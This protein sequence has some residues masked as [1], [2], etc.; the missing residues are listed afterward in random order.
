L[1]FVKIYLQPIYLHGSSC[2]GALLL[3]FI[4][5]IRVLGTR[6]LFCRLHICTI[7]KKSCLNKTIT[8]LVEWA[9]GRESLGN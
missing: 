3:F 1:P 6:E 2:W 5:F 4:F 8:H 9:M 7:R